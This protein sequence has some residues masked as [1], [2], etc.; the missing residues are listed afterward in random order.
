MCAEFASFIDFDDSVCCTGCDG[1]MLCNAC[2][3]I[4]TFLRHDESFLANY[5]VIQSTE[6]VKP[7]KLESIVAK[8]HLT[9]EEERL[10]QILKENHVET[11]FL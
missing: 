2:A 11:K 7:T 5:T 8:N 6:V 3:E 9:D 10:L 4:A 1:D